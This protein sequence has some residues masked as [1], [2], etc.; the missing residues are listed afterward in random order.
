M[1]ARYGKIVHCNNNRKKPYA[2]SRTN[3]RAHIHMRAHTNSYTIVEGSFEMC[4]HV[5]VCLFV[6]VRLYDSASMDECV[7]KCVS[8]RVLVCELR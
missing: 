3:A 8:V 4:A 5:R 1:S 7:H 2:F 6:V